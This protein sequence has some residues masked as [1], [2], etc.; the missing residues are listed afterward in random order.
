MRSRLFGSL[1]AVYKVLFEARFERRLDSYTQRIRAR[2]ARLILFSP[3]L[4][5]PVEVDES[6]SILGTYAT[7]RSKPIV[8]LVTA[9]RCPDPVHHDF[10]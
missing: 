3:H 6:A 4:A 8:P 1:L 7:G 10:R 5:D 9:L 2:S